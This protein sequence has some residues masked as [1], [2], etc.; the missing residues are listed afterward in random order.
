VQ[1]QTSS[2]EDVYNRFY[3]TT[4]FNVNANGGQV[5]IEINFKEAVDYD[6]GTGV[7]DLNDNIL[8]WEY[9][10]NIADIVE[11]VSYQVTIIKSNFK[12]GTFTQNLELVINT[13]PNSDSAK[14]AAG[15]NREKQEDPIVT[16]TITGADATVGSQGMLPEPGQPTAA[17][18]Q[19]TNGLSGSGTADDDNNPSGTVTID[20]DGRGD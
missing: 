17:A 13:F 14:T 2:I 18:V 8:F 19:V 1:D 11:G 12:S 10:E 15:D 3:G 16:P 9:P 6:E 5:F 7:L 4:G 20:E